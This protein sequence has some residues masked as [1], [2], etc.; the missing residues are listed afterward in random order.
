M[1]NADIAMYH[2]KEEGKN[3]FQF[4][5]EHMDTHSLERLALESSL[6]RALERNEF[7][8]HYQAK[9]DLATGQ[10]TGMEALIALAAPGSGNGVARAIH[11]DCRGDRS[12]RADRKV[13]AQD[14]LSAEPGLAER[15]SAAFVGGG[16]SVGAAIR[17][18]KPA[19]GHRRR[20]LK[21]T[22][23]KPE[24]PGARN[25]REHDHAQRR[26]RRCRR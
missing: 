5:S 15:R 1:K 19:C 4:H 6:R 2:A 26:Q 10:M 12:D 21:E 13:G 22:G 8:L 17:R 24:L 16:Q 18:R 20:I 25:H 23:M 11:P 3:N 7:E 9:I 14:R